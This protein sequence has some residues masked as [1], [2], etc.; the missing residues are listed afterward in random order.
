MIVYI[1]IFNYCI[2]SRHADAGDFKASACIHTYIHS[3]EH[4]HTYRDMYGSTIEPAFLS[5]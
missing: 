4:C 3:Q 2:L 5:L 1:S